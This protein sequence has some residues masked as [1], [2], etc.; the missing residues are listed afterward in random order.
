MTRTAHRIPLRVAAVVGSVALAAGL[1]SCGESGNAFRPDRE[2][3]GYALPRPIVTLNAGTTV[4]VAT[5]AAKVSARLY[6]GAFLPGPTGQLLPNTDLVQA[7]PV[8]GD[9]RRVNYVINPKATFSDG[10]PVTCQDFL[11]AKAAGDHPEY[12]SSD[13]PLMAQVE[14]L[15]CETGAKAFQVVFHEGF[16]ARYRELFAAGTVMPAHTVAT[17]AGVEDVVG[18]IYS[19]NPAAL[20]TLGEQW[21][22]TFRV[23]ET[24]PADV[25]TFGPYKVTARSES[26]VLTL[27]PNSSYG[28]DA[29]EEGRILLHPSSDDVGALVSSKDLVVADA[30]PTKD[31]SPSGLTSPGFRSAGSSGSRV[32]TLRLAPVGT[33]ASVD[34]RQGF[35]ACID[36]ARVATAVKDATGVEVAPTGLRILSPANPLASRLADLNGA[37]SAVDRQRTRSVLGGATVTVGYLAAVPRY[38]AMVDAVRASCAEAGVT[39]VPVALK[40]D[41]FGALGKDYDALLDTRSSFGRNA[42]TDVEVTASATQLPKIREAEQKLAAD[43]VTLPLTTEPRFVAVEEHISGVVDNSGDTGLSWNMDRWHRED[44]PVEP[45]KSG[46]A[47]PQA[48]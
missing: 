31:M 43:S 46:A 27:E 8:P 34:A 33:F 32:D 9:A 45:S 10:V 12:F 38:A 5:D 40:A 15:N 21:Q 36:R 23:A 24:N 18:A 3:F 1:A 22:K 2:E 25:P 6:P 19:A 16:G 42:A 41:E 35:G 37:Q 48:I 26:G 11:L 29:P 14:S 28:G 30:V 44:Q 20:E 47:D 17:R 13:L 7:D 4:G 39:V